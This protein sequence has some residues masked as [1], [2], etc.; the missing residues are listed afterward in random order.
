MKIRILI[1]F[2]V[3]VLSAIAIVWFGKYRHPR[4][5]P[6][7]TQILLK[8]LSQQFSKGRMPQDEAT[9]AYLLNG[10]LLYQMKIPKGADRTFWNFIANSGVEAGKM[11]FRYLPA[12]FYGY[13]PEKEGDN[14]PLISENGFLSGKIRKI[15]LA[16]NKLGQTEFICQ[17]ALS[18]S[19]ISASGIPCFYY[20][21]AS[22]G[23]FGSNYSKPRLFNEITEPLK[24]VLDS[25][26]KDAAQYELDETKMDNSV[27]K[28]Q[29][30]YM[31]QA[32]CDSDSRDPDT[33]Y[34]LETRNLLNSTDSYITIYELAKHG[35]N[36][37]ARRL[38]NAEF[39]PQGRR[40][41]FY[42]K[43]HDKSPPSFMLVSD[44]SAQ[45]YT[46]RFGN[47]TMIGKSI[48]FYPEYFDAIVK[49][50]S[51]LKL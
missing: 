20:N 10:M 45:F 36:W 37:V 17:L 15:G 6:D 8:G 5:N 46:W 38:S 25:L 30:S 26:G 31:A 28:P 27:I 18:D 14:I 42:I 29:G 9:F 44:Y 3:G 7:T 41:S 49:M 43:N 21:L 19:R 34:L 13:F 50:D 2:A 33:L 48:D 16:F 12:D 23:H 11:G 47:L 35:N 39:G 51:L 32:Y 40:I 24:A 1:Y 22:A 4:K